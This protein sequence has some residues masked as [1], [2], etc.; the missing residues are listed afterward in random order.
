MT[1]ITI[2]SGLTAPFRLAGLILACVMMGLTAQ[3]ALFGS[4]PVPAG[5]EPLSSC[6]SLRYEAYPTLRAYIARNCY[7]SAKPYSE[8]SAWAQQD[9]QW[10][11]ASL[12]DYPRWQVGPFSILARRWVRFPRYH[13]VVAPPDW[14]ILNAPGTYFI[15]VTEFVVEW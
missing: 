6:H 8:I 2:P 11:L 12:P 7:Y 5:S 1:A 9:Q 4:H 3:W 10:V 14:Y 13:G 15:V